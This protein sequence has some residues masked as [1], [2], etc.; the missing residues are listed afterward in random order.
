MIDNTH[1]LPESDAELATVQPRWPLLLALG[2][3]IITALL[4]MSLEDSHSLLGNA[5]F[6]ITAV[7]FPGILGSIAITGN[8]HAFS[9]WI[10]AGINFIFYFVLFWVIC[11]V[12]RW[13]VRR[14]R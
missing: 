4:S 3:G 5:G 8:A 7:L 2:V 12:S 6:I 10:A 11:S 13:I 9:Y 1:N 14:F